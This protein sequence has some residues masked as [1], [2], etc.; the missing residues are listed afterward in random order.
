[1]TNIVISPGSNV[2]SRLRMFFK[3]TELSLGTG[4]FHETGGAYHL[5]TNWHNVSGRHPRTLQPL[6]AH[7]GL[8]DRIKLTVNE[9]GR[10]GHWAEVE[11]PLYSDAD[12]DQP[13]QPVWYVHPQFQQTVDVVAI[14]FQPPPG[15][16]IH[17]VNTVN[18]I[19][20]LRLAVAG[21]VFVLGYPKGISGGGA[22]PIWKR[23]SIA[24]E[25]QIDLD[26]LPMMLVD[27]ATREGMSGAP[28]LALASRG[29]YTDEQGNLF[30]GREGSRFV[31]IYSGRLGDNEME[32]QLGV[33]WKPKVIEEIVNNKVAGTSSFLWR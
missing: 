10:L 23:A 31:G 25:P 12:A 18:T 3:K 22:F 11:L 26:N 14:P 9:A 13:T 17:P 16:E 4:F 20:N 32:A 6:S 21:D 27:T 30:A 19:S 1:M 29:G 28:A 5:I 7:A 2:T 8:P 33:I 15:T 24:S